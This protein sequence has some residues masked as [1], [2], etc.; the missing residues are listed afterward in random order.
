M[1]AA[2]QA[3]PERTTD[4]PTE[5]AQLVAEIEHHNRAYHVDAAPEISD[6]EF[7]ALFQ[8]LLALEAQFP[9]LRTPAS[10]SQGVG[11]APGGGF[12]KVAHSVPMLSLTNAFSVDDAAEFMAR[13]RR[14]LGLG[15][16]TP[17]ELAGEPKIDGLSA[18]LRYVDGRFVQGATR[19]DGLVGEDITANLRTVADIPTELP[20]GAPALLDVRGEVYMTYPDF[21][22]LNVRQEEADAKLFANPR[23]AAAGSLRQ[24]DPSVT[25]T[26]RLHFFAY[27]WGEASQTVADTHLAFLE[28]LAGWGFAVNPL[29]RACGG[30]A[31]VAAFYAELGDTRAKLGYDID[32]IVFKVNRLDWQERL[33]FV[34]RAPRWAVALKFPPQQATTV[35]ERIAIQVGRTGA[36]TPVAELKPVTVGGVVVQ[37]A[38]LHNEDEIARKDI[39]AG[40]TVIVQR[41]GDVI[42]QIV[43]VI[44]GKRPAKSK[45]YA[46]PTR[47]PVCAS[48]AVRDEGEAVRRCT[49]GLIC[50]A[51][52]LERLK[53]FVSRDAFDI[54]GLGAKHIEAF[55]ADGLLRGP[56]DIF[57]LAEHRA[58][59]AAREGWGE[60]SAVNLLSAI[61]ERRTIPLDRFIYA[62]GIRHVGQ[63]T[64]RL[65]AKT[66]GALG[67]WRTA[68][69][70]AADCEGEAYGE[71]V[72]VDG[73]G[74]SVAA[75]VVAFM[76]EPHNV[77]VLDALAAALDVTEF[78]PPA[79]DSPVAGKTI[80]FTGTLERMTRHEA[81]A[82][83]EALGAKVAGSVSKK[84]DIVVAGPGA[85]SKATKARELGLEVID[86]DAWLELVGSAEPDPAR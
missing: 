38:T 28:A 52:A 71:L 51:Q 32:G 11:A 47:C 13:T 74:P 20:A 33:G 5:H 22:A 2:P 79:G 31:D 24:L 63:A 81:K 12:A 80:V 66:Y 67:A 23:N 60:Q 19:G 57:A 8:R 4:A 30:L 44:T 75:D 61:D 65:L 10:P 21:L 34:S 7:D 56:A 82:R 15:D 59:L 84:T 62:L 83:A 46:F 48:A 69:A 36:L 3:A 6:A 78:A 37:R 72:A 64:A 43:Q 68:M 17:V 54:E 18:S 26:R 42:P 39:R 55:W 14:F 85:G 35:L 73:I 40:D 9:E 49:G 58:A 25:A 70:A 16:E 86:E 77:A 29:R 53:H 1:T 41:A 50:E 45:R 76:A 27:A